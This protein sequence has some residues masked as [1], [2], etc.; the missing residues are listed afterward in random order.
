MG[1]TAISFSNHIPLPGESL[2]TSHRRRMRHHAWAQ[3]T[4]DLNRGENAV[5]N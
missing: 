1:H 2:L 4:Y 5:M 3:N